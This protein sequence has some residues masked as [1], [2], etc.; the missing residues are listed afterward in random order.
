[1]SL[2]SLGNQSFGGDRIKEQEE[3]QSNKLDVKI[4]IAC[5]KSRVIF[6]RISWKEGSTPM[7][8]GPPKSCPISLQRKKDSKR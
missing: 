8:S 3:K 1:M 7:S 5:Y 4:L 6:I 2:S